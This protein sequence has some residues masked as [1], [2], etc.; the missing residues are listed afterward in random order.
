MNGSNQPIPQMQPTN[1]PPQTSIPPV[2]ENRNWLKWILIVLIVALT[3]SATTYFVMNQSQKPTPLPAEVSTTEGDLYREPNGSAA[4]ANWKTYTD[5]KFYSLK[6]PPTLYQDTSEGIS[7]N[8]ETETLFRDKEWREDI[9]ISIK[10]GAFD[11]FTQD[12]RQRGLPNNP[13]STEIDGVKALR[14]E[15]YSGEAGRLKTVIVVAQKNDY[16]YL[17]MFHT[18]GL[19]A[20]NEDLS[21]FNQI[22]ST[23]RFD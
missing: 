20:N 14:Y 19:P 16:A 11:E 4:T 1:P 18:P 3:S 17:I 22:L 15:G 23:F 21:V 5:N 7:N 12:P 8:L 6:L 2:E 9:Y 10:K 13:T